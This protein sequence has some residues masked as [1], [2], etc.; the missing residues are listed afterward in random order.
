[1][2]EMILIYQV[3][4]SCEVNTK[5]DE[6]LNCYSSNLCSLVNTSFP[7]FLYRSASFDVE[8]IYTFRAHV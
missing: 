5:N 8:P 6:L 1:M 4:A 7:I 2:Y 3:M